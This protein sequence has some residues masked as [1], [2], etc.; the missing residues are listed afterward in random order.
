MLLVIYVERYVIAI[1]FNNKEK[2]NTKLRLIF[3]QLNVV[4]L[5]HQYQ[6]L[7]LKFADV[8]RIPNLLFSWNNTLTAFAN[9][10]LTAFAN[11]LKFA[12]VSREV[13]KQTQYS[14]LPIE[15][16]I[17]VIYAAVKKQ[18]LVI[19]AAVNGFCDRIPIFL[20]LWFLK[21]WLFLYS[22]IRSTS[23]SRFLDGTSLFQFQESP[24]V[25]IR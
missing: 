17:L 7:V 2:E 5:I 21:A 22:F 10:Y 18:I 3:S 16:Q 14:P 23:F 13:P 8:S 25:K 4:L 19:Y 12:D 20:K 6:I 11:F 1:I 24:V 15:K 9:M